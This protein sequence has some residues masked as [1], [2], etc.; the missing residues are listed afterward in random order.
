[1]NFI[2]VIFENRDAIRPRIARDPE[3]TQLE[4][5]IRLISAKTNSEQVF[6]VCVKAHPISDSS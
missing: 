3:D 6:S 4:T 1:M 5:L 2:I